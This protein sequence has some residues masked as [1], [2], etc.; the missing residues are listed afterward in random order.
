MISL[1]KWQCSVDNGEQLAQV[2]QY[3][4]L[5][6]STTYLTKYLLTLHIFWILSHTAICTFNQLDWQSLSLLNIVVTFAGGILDLEAETSEVWG[7]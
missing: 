5:E 4:Y 2:P 3:I 6:N 7:I 1:L